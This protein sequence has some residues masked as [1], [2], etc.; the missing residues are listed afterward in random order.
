[1]GEIGNVWFS[2]EDRIPFHTF[3]SLWKG[4]RSTVHVS[5]GL[6]AGRFL[7][8]DSVRGGG[9]TQLNADTP[10]LRVGQGQSE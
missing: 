5:G 7:T 4:G 2:A 6:V 9:I 3:D 8:A 10:S 1:M